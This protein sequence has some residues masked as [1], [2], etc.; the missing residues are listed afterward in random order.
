MK[1]AIISVVLTIVALGVG[2]GCRRSGTQS[3]RDE[4]Y[5]RLKALPPVAR[6]FST[7]EGA[8]LCLEDAYRRRDL[9]AAIAAKD[10]KTEARLMLQKTGF[11]DQIDDELIART[12]EALVAS[13]RAHT[14][15]SWPDFE[16]LESFFTKREPHADK[17]VLVTEMCRFPDG[18]Y[19]KQQMLVA[20]TPQGWRVLNP[21]SE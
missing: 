8:I 15:A 1:S 2:L 9:E 19:S 12:A 16:G 3:T 11:K 4:A 20:E 10:F 5:A 18:G 13:F 21:V 17:V 6:D 7:P 14:T